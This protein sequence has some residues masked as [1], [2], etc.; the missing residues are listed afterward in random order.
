MKKNQ[1]IAL[2]IV[3]SLLVTSAIGIAI[4][5]L[6]KKDDTEPET[7][8]NP[9]VGNR[10]IEEPVSSG[11]STQSSST[12][13]SNPSYSNLVEPAF[14][15][16]NELSNPLHQIKGKVLYPKNSQDGGWGYANV[17]S[18]AEVNNDQGWWDGSDNLIT[19]IKS[20]TPIGVVLSETSGIYNGYSY[21]WLKVKL[22]KPTGG[23]FSPYT[24]GYVRADT[25][26]FKA[27]KR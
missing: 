10:N 26:T 18:S 8:E 7:D 21:R 24:Q 15:A 11:S 5:Q 1:K 16:E 12:S 3:G 17:R 13:T 20:N 14:N 4:Y 19:S 6:T 9:Y 27:Y 2:I 23:W 22:L 25:V